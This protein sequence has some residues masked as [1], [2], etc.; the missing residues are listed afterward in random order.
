MQLIPALNAA[1][2]SDFRLSRLNSLLLH[3]SS[4]IVAECA[5]DEPMLAEAY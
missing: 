2:Y 5:R 1:S 3:V 4:I